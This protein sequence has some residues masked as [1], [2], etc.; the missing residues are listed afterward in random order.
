LVA[1]AERA[2]KINKSMTP[3]AKGGGAP[4]FLDFEKLVRAVLST[5][6]TRQRKNG[7]LMQRTGWPVRKTTATSADFDAEGAAVFEHPCALGCEGM[8]RSALARLTGQPDGP[9]GSRPRTE[10]RLR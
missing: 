7:F 4:K 10:A 3:T 5:R 8:S 9:I 2:A 6:A 1:K